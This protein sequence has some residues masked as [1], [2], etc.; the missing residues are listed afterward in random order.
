LEQFR[1]FVRGYTKKLY[2]EPISKLLIKLKLTPNLVTLLGLIITIGGSYLV[3]K[4]DFF[5]G[6]IVI[7]IGTMLDSIDGSMARLSGKVSK[8]GD[9]LDSVIDRY[10]EGIIFI[11]IAS[12]YIFQEL[13]KLAILLCII[14]LLCSQ[15]IS[16]TRAKCESLNI[17]NKSGLFTRVERSM[18]LIVFLIISQP[19]LGLY[20]LV[21]GTSISSFWRLI[22]GLKNA[23]N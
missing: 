4:G 12:F 6:G 7:A 22:A 14:S 16:Y 13:N 2:E 20:I 18:I 23:Q 11:G 21:I 9:L 3:F 17:E 19:L 8:Y 5:I 10:S 15:L 1:Q